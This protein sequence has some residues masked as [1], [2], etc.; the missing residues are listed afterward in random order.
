VRVPGLL[1]WPE[2]IE[3]PRTLSMPC[4]TSD[5]FPTIMDIL[6]FKHRGPL[7]PRDGVSL[8]PMIRGETGTRP[9]PIA[10][11]SGDQLSLVDNRYKV[12]SRDKGK[13]FMLFDLKEDSSESKD[14]SKSLPELAESMREILL[15]WQ[16]SCDMSREGR[17]YYFPD[18]NGF[19]P[20]ATR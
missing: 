7:E 20:T 9:V 1:V 12:I 14:L 3:K 11:E 15:N 10:F 4:S 2:G 16:A 13:T 18:S 8:L 6:G 17:D 19:S 5:Y